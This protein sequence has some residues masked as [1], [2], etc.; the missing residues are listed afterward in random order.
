MAFN[1]LKRALIEA[2]ILHYL[3]PSKCYMVYTDASNDACG[4]QLLQEH[5]GQ[6]LPVAFLSHTFT[7]TKQK[8]STTE[9]EAY[10][11]YY[12]LSKWNYYIQGSDIV[13]CN[14]HKPP[15]KFLNGKNANN[16]VNRWSLELAT[17]NIT[18]EW[19]SG[20]HKSAACLSQLVDFNDTPV[21]STASINILVISSPDGPATHTHSKTCTP[22]DTTPPIDVKTTSNTDKMNAPPL[23]MDDCKDTPQLM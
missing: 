20:A 3:D 17:Y 19:I 13:V 5:N 7:D 4:D 1:T 10:G 16:K 23:L 9:Q 8:W 15:Q 22:T 2:P 6:Q 18:F 11:I 21:T 14:D 12:A